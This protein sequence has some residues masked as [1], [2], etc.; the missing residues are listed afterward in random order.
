[1]FGH[2]E[3]V[4]IKLKKPMGLPP[5]LETTST[6]L[7]MGNIPVGVGGF[8]IV[9]ILLAMIYCSMV[10]RKETELDQGRGNAPATPAMA[11]PKFRDTSFF[12]NQSLVSAF[13]LNIFL[14]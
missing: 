3:V 4:T 12:A 8:H 14:C 13:L 1:M 7:G 5:Q 11:G 2:K 9:S 10:Y 6:H